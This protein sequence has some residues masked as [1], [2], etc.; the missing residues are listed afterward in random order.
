MGNSANLAPVCFST[1]QVRYFALFV[2]YNVFRHFDREQVLDTVHPE[3]DHPFEF[4]YNFVTSL[5][6]SHARMS[7]SVTKLPA[8]DIIKFSKKVEISLNINLFNLNT[9]I[10]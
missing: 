9:R 8:N 4:R 6:K 2:S 1:V 3:E 10:W 7:R 5:V